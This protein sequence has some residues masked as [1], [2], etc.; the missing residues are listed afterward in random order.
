MWCTKM[1]LYGRHVVVD[2]ASHVSTFTTFAGGVAV[3]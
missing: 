3:V 2:V 1:L